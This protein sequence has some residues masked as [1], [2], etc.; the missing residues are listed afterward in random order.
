[1]DV[2]GDVGGRSVSI[3]WTPVRELSESERSDAHDRLCAA[4][5]A[6]T[7]RPA[8]D[9]ASSGGCHVQVSLPGFDEVRL[10]AASDDDLAAVVHDVERATGRRL[11]LLPLDP[12]TRQDA[13]LIGLA[14][15]VFTAAVASGFVASG[16][17]FAGLWFGSAVA[18]FFFCWAAWTASVAQ[19]G[20]RRRA[21]EAKLAV[22]RG[23]APAA[24][25]VRAAAGSAASPAT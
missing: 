21:V 4:V 6:L 22:L 5:P 15:S 18:I 11:H 23:A 13:W 7:T 24:A 19:W 1:V 3:S 16:Y 9:S 8:A 2:H 12:P 20:E 10:S 14:G 25:P 17:G